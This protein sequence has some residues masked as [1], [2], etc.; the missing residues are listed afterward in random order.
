M[1]SRPRRRAESPVCNGDFCVHW[2]DTSKDKPEL[3]DDNGIGDGDGVPDYVEEVLDSAEDSFDRENTDLGWIEPVRR[4]HPRRRAGETDVY[5]LDIDKLYYGYA[6]PDEGQG[7]ATSKESYLV[8]DDDYQR[9]A[10]PPDFTAVEAMQ[11]TMAHEYNHVLQFAYDSQQDTWMFE[12]TATWME[13]MVYP[14]ID[15]YIGYLPFYARAVDD[16]AHFERSRG[17]KIYGA[18][19]WNHFLADAESPTSSATRG[20]PRPRPTIPACRS[21]PTTMPSAESGNPYQALS[22]S[23]ASSRPAASSGAAESGV[24]EDATEFP[25]IKRKGKLKPGDP[26][27]LKLDHLSLCAARHPRRRCRRGHDARGEGPGRDVPGD[28]ASTAGTGSATTGAI[29]GQSSGHR[30]RTGASHP[31]ES[32]GATYDRVTAMVANDDAEVN[33]AG[34]KYKRDNQKFKVKLSTGP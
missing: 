3:D 23:S 24:Y 34:T 13:N 14:D 28:R 29:S 8:L 32:P 11:V 5:L 27:K 6:S 20:T 30:A 15:D 31:C 4:R 21:R 17:L 16:P 22:Q 18:A 33:A 2:V 25:D 26:R 1:A 10:S 7:P 9:L 12:S 19:V